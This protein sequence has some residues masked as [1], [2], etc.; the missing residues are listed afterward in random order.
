[1]SGGRWNSKETACVYAA[2]SE[3]L[4]ILEMLVRAKSRVV[5]RHYCLFEA[6]LPEKSVLYLKGLPDDWRAI[7]SETA[8]IGDAWLGSGGSLA[9][10]VPSA[11]VP[12][13]K[14]YLLNPAHARFSQL[15]KK[16]KILPF[17]FDSRLHG[18][19]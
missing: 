18:P 7:P 16:A 17:E 11:I 10:A 3:S 2:S 8:E 5:A 6:R 1:L 13:E 12:R 9:L 4:A 19:L 14:M 15:A